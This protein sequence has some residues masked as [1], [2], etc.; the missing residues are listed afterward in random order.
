L[1]S[2]DDSFLDRGTEIL[3]DRTAKDLIDPFETGTR[4]QRFKDTF[5]ISELSAP[6]R[7]FLVTSLDF[8][9]L[10]DRF[11]VRNF[12]RMQCDL[13]VISLFEFLDDSLDMKLA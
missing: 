13:D 4:G 7:L 2:F 5:A 11:L 12:R 10:R 9:L 6:A 1:S 3:R 8:Y